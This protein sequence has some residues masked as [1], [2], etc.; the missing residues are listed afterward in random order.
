MPK[1]F[2]SRA[3]VS[4]FKREQREYDRLL[5]Q[6]NLEDPEGLQH[7]NSLVQEPQNVR[8]TTFTG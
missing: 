7:R 8:L 4:K 6:L 3:K 5:Q 1:E 2:R